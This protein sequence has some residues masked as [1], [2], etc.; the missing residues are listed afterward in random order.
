MPINSAVL[1]VDISVRLPW[2]SILTPIKLYIFTFTKM[3]ILCVYINKDCAKFYEY[4]Y[5]RQLN[6]VRRA[7]FY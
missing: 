3:Y 2:V 5:E 4:M 1:H 6:E 7:V